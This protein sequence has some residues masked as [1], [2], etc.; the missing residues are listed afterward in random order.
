MAFLNRVPEPVAASAL[1]R[2]PLSSMWLFLNTLVCG[3]GL[4]P[5]CMVLA[6]GSGSQAV[7]QSL[8]RSVLG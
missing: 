1:G 2:A 3:W 6:G 7:V 5:G 4:F 8:S